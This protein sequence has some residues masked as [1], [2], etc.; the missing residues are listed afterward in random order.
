ECNVGYIV[1]EWVEDNQILSEIERIYG[2]NSNLPT[3][4]IILPLKPDKVKPVKQ[5]LSSIH[6]EDSKADPT[7][8]KVTAI[9][10]SSEKNFV[11]RK[12][13]DAESQRF[14]VRPENKVERR[15]EVEEYVITLAF[16]NGERLQ[17]GS[18][19][20]PGIYAF[21]PTEMS[22]RETILLD[23]KW[24]LGILNCV[25]TAFVSAFISLV[26]E[27]ENAPVSLLPRMFRFLPITGSPYALLNSVR[28]QIQSKLMEESII[29]C[30]SYTMQKFFHKPKEVGRL[31][32]GFW[33]LLEL[34]RKQGVC[35][36]NISTHGK[37]ILSSAFDDEANN[38]FLGFL[39]VGY[40]D[41]EWYAKCVR[42]SNLV[43]GGGEDLYLKL[44]LFVAE[45]WSAFSSTS[46]VDIPVLKYVGAQS[47]VSLCKVNEV[48][49]K[50]KILL[51]NLVYQISWLIDWNGEFVGVSNSY[52]LPESTLREILS[53]SKRQMIWDWLVKQ[54]KVS[55]VSVNDYALHLSKVLGNDR[56]RI[57]TYAHFLYHSF[58]KKYLS[59]TEVNEAAKSM[60]LV[61]NYGQVIINR[62]RVVVPANGSRWMQLVGSNPWR[63]KGYVELGE[64]YLFS[65]NYAGV[66]TR[67]K[68]LIKFLKSHVSASDV[69]DLP[70]PNARIPSFSSLLTKENALLLL[71]WIRN[72]KRKQLKMPDKFLNCV[73]KGSWLRVL[74]GNSVSC[75]PPSQSFLLTNSACS[76]L[77]QNGS[78]LVDIPLVDKI[79][80]G[81]EISK[82]KDELRE[83]GVMSEF[84]EA[85][86]YIGNRLMSIAASSTLTRA[87]V[88]SILNFIRFLRDKLLSPNAFI[89]RIK[90]KRWLRTSQGDR[91]PIETVLYDQ[92]WKAASQICDIPFID[93]EYY[94]EKISSFRKELHLLG[95][96]VS[97]SGNYK[98]IVD[99]LKSPYHSRYQ[100]ADVVLLLLEC[101]R[102]LSSSDSTSSEK[103]VRVLK[104]SMLLKTTN[105]GYKSPASCVLS[106]PSWDCLMQVFNSFSLIDTQF[107]G[108]ENI[109]SFGDELAKVGV[110]IDFKEATK[111]FACVFRQQVSSSSIN[112]ENVLSFLACYR[113]LKGKFH[114]DLK[115]CIKEVKWLRTRLTDYRAP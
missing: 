35:L 56:K 102:H 93:H 20:S 80:Y 37:Y 42:S 100:A 41:E 19:N 105:K 114:S 63:D 39:K 6:P 36:D 43:L 65:G 44:L 58:G 96:V 21:L 59:A 71:E 49:R 79:F 7:S 8:N 27:K 50:R 86:Q 48:S 33:D 67:E 38:D 2:S 54:V 40:V 103:I 70:P 34:A 53:H 15:A 101:M 95:V 77:L 110:L 32:P 51:S 115:K 113:K 30:E 46:L 90:D 29:P 72:M 66:V 60:P 9:S 99:N 85:C 76:S 111:A 45:N 23:C 91:S 16:P 3:T 24:N 107:Y 5:Q 28:E 1:P 55:F 18:S 73:K 4:T 62:Q 81:K 108:E 98:L 64:D 75:K 10:I 69:P 87:H 22:S 11:T 104:D 61:D 74:L 82:Y 106:D 109:S 78:V 47:Q 25:P 97:F 88:F 57:V 26:K 17:R 68:E 31:R 84:S 14:R 92:E 89:S 83:V 94:G 12:N 112:K 52:F 13:I